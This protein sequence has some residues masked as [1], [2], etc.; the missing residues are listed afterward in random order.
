MDEP[1]KPKQVRKRRSS[2]NPHYID[3]KEF[4]AAI[5]EWV[6][7][8]GKDKETRKRKAR[9]KWTDLPDYVVECFMKLAEHYALQG[10]WRGYTY[11]DEMKAEARLNCVKYAH[12]FDPERGNAFAYFTQ[13]VTNSF[14]QILASEK[15]QADLKFGIIS[16]NSQHCLDRINLYDE[17]SASEFHTYGE[18]D[19]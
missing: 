17:E 15:K 6:L 4:T 13:Y 3:N 2:D 11:V 10:N 19:E 1:V 16:D 8:N 7:E 12:N 5:S 18:D 9:S 14:L